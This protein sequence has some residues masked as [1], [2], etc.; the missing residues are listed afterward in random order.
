MQILQLRFMLLVRSTIGL[1]AAVVFA[2]AALAS[3]TGF[4]FGLDLGLSRYPNNQELTVPPGLVLI[5]S[6]SHLDQEDTAWGVRAGYQL[7][8]YFAVE[9]GYLD[10]GETSG[11]FASG[12][13]LSTFTLSGS[14]PTVALVGKWPLGN[15]EPYLRLGVFFADTDLSFRLTDGTTAIAGTTSDST[16]EVFG[17]LG[18]GYRF[19]ERWRAQVELTVFDDVSTATVGFT[20]RF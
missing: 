16:E 5:S 14:G 13:S 6:G 11:T 20:Y 19:S 2:P 18:I 9:A 7:N 4:Y 1:I 12:S 17:G 8:S 3:D 15:W 10:L